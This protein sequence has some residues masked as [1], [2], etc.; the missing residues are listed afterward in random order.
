MIKYTKYC[1]KQSDYM[2]NKIYC[3]WCG[4]EISKE[5]KKCAACGKK[6]PPKDKLFL[7]FLIEHTKDS[8][9]GNI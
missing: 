5:D 8:I 3:A 9:K 2:D 1:K 6:L 7:E 4:T